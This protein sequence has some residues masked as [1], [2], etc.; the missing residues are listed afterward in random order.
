VPWT[1]EGALTMM[2]TQTGA[3]WA[4]G[5]TGD[6]ARKWTKVSISEP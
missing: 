2:D 3:V 4:M 5:T 1:S 6:N